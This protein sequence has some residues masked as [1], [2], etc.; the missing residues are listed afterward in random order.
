MKTKIGIKFLTIMVIAIALSL[1]TVGSVLA[2]HENPSYENPHLIGPAIVGTVM[3]DGSGVAKFTGACKGETVYFD[4]GT[5]LTDNVAGLTIADVQDYIVSGGMNGL[6]DCY[7]G[8]VGDLIVNTVTKFT[9]LGTSVIA[10]VVVLG[11]VG[12]KK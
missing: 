1:G 5:S 3:I 8:Q 12:S 10:D 6:A 9:N 4:S 2:N 7:N 11:F